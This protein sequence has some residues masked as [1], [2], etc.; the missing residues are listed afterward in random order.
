L[1]THLPDCLYR[2]LFRRYEPLNLPFSCKVVENRSAVF[3]LQIFAGGGSKKI[4]SSLLLT[5]LPSVWQS[6]VEFNGLKCRQ[7]RKTHNFLRVGENAGPILSRL[8]TKV[9][10]VLRRFRKSLVVCNALARL[11]ISCFIPKI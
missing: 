3:G 8:W 10:V 5:L 9:H 7:W 2:L 6:L 11:C 4:Y 1:P